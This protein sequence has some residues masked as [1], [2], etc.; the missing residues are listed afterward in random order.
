MPAC[1]WVRSTDVDG[2]PVN[3]WVCLECGAI[4][5]LKPDMKS[6]SCFAPKRE[7]GQPPSAQF[8]E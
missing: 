5:G 6:P 8:Q 7:K 4:K 3:L 1:D 2:K